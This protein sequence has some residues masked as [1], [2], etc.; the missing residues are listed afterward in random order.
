M[1]LDPCVALNLCISHPKFGLAPTPDS[2]VHRQ[3][4]IARPSQE[5][6]N[7]QGWRGRAERSRTSRKGGES[8]FK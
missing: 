1:N 3:A 2:Q 7:S 4:L 8:G 6:D 5:G